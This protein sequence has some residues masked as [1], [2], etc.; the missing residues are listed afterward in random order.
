MDAFPQYSVVRVKAL[1]QPRDSYD[2]WGVNRRAPVVGGTGTVV[3]IL[4]SPGAPTAY[5]VECGNADGTA[6]W[7]ADLTAQELEPCET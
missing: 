1:L 7:L 3:E 2:S 6:E 5:V 4:R